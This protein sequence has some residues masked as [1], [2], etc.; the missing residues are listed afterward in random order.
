MG[1]GSDHPGGGADGS[2]SCERSLAAVKS[3]VANVASD[4]KMDASSAMFVA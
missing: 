3:G 4:D 2:V 1:M